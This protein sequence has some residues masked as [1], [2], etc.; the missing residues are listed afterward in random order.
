MQGQNK[1][2]KNSERLDT[3]PKNSHRFVERVRRECSH[4]SKLVANTNYD[5]SA[6]NLILFRSRDSVRLITLF[7]MQ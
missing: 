6:A 5:V 2:N 7:R 4:V 1:R 3:E